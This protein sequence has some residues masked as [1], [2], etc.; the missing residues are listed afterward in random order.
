MNIKSCTG[1]TL[2]NIMTCVPSYLFEAAEFLEKDSTSKTKNIEKSDTISPKV[3]KNN[4]AGN[5]GESLPREL[6][7][8]SNVC[9][10]VNYLQLW[11]TQHLGKEGLWSKL[12]GDWVCMFSNPDR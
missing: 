1:N 11:E 5:K 6:S 7:L 3:F 2:P 10:F 8:L 9:K 12:L 4:I